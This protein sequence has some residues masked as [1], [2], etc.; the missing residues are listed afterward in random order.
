MPHSSDMESES[1]R[2][3]RIGKVID[4]QGYL[5][6]E[7]A[8]DLLIETDPSDPLYQ[9]RLADAISVGTSMLAVAVRRLDAYRPDALEALGRAVASFPL[10]NE[11]VAQLTRAASDRRST[12]ARRVGAMLVLEYCLGA[13]AEEDFLSTLR[14]PTTA[15]ALSFQGA[16][17][18]AAR[19]SILQSYVQALLTQPS[20][21]LYA[22]FSKLVALEGDVSPEVARLLA[23]HPDAE[24]SLAIVDALAAQGSKVAVQ[25]LSLLA[26]NLSLDAGHAATRALHKLRLAG[27]DPHFLK[28]PD[29]SCRALLSP[30]DGSG[31]RL[32]MLIAPGREAGTTAMLEMYL[33]EGEGLLEVCA[34]PACGPFDVPRPADL[35]HTHSL[36]VKSWVPGHELNADQPVG[37]AASSTSE[38]LEVPYLYGLDVLGESV[39]SNWLSVTPLPLAYCLLAHLFWL[40]SDGLQEVS[41]GFEENEDS[42]LPQLAAREADLLVNPAFDSWYLASPSAREVAEE[43]S[44]LSGGPPR[45]LTDD[46]WRLLLPALIRLAHD[47]FSPPVRDLYAAR[48]RYMAE[49]LHLAGHYEDAA[50]AAS[51]ART[52]LKSPPETNL[53][54]LRLVQRGILVALGQLGAT[55]G[56]RA[57]KPA[58]G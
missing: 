32:L 18:G 13:P 35:G 22:V 36:P 20:E 49:W 34:Y 38:M 8:L 40:H 12:D 19:S 26:P 30:I 58:V 43:I 57:Y 6:A 37:V 47:E 52:M 23:L 7:R 25:C 51:A 48:L 45:E 55:K 3:T 16:A 46:N 10:R 17:R 56:T 15:L 50:Y 5:S 27:Y 42:L 53:L 1:R 28:S 41:F 44:T 54:V 29:E 4:L 9:H 14:D 24:L 2:V 31:N 33:S 21:L 39:K 11:A